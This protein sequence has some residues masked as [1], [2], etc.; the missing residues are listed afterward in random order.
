VFS[1]PTPQD[2]HALARVLG[3]DYLLVGEVERRAYRG[4]PGMLA[5]RPDLFSLVFHNDAVDIYGVRQ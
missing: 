2:A 4:A 5:A 3:I 1:A